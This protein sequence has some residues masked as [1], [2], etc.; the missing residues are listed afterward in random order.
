MIVATPSILQAGSRYRSS[1]YQGLIDHTGVNRGDV[2]FLV[3]RQCTFTDWEEG[4]RRD[5]GDPGNCT[6]LINGNYYEISLD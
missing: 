5:G 3:L 1:S 4:L 2:P 6:A